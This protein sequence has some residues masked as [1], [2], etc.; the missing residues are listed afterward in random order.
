M[1]ERPGRPL[2]CCALGAIVALSTAWFAVAHA[3]PGVPTIVLESHVGQRGADVETALRPVIDELDRLGFAARPGS[4]EKLLGGRA[5]R[6]GRLDDGTTVADI[7]QLIAFGRNAFDKAKFGDAEAAHRRAVDLIR[8]NPALLVLDANNEKVTY[9]AF[10]GLSLSLFKLKHRAEATEVMLELLRMSSTPIPQADYGPKAEDIHGDAE[11]EA[12]VLGRGSLAI[13]VHDQR[14]MIFVDQKFGGMG[15]IAV[16]DLIAGPH[17]VL[18]QMPGTRG[19]QYTRTVQ[20][21]RPIEL[22]VNWQVESMLHLDD[23]WAGFVFATEVERGKET[24]YASDLVRRLG[25]A[26]VI[27]LRTML[28]DGISY[29]V[30]TQYPANGRAPIA[31]L[32]P[33]SGGE[34]LLRSLARFL[35]DGTMAA[36]LRVLPRASEGASPTVALLDSTSPSRASLL[37]KVATGV[38]ALAIAVGAIEYVRNPYNPQKPAEYDGRTPLVEVMLGGSVALGGGVYLWVR[39]MRP[40][41][42][43]TAALLG[44]GIAGLTAGAE[45]YL[46]N[47]EAVPNSP[48]YIRATSSMGVGVGLVGVAM[49]G[50]G[51]WRLYREDND[52]VASSSTRVRQVDTAPIVAIDSSRAFVGLGGSF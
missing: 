37:P 13:D 25:G 20:P 38:G 33:M 6:P 2:G 51:L 1:S 46:T 44:A 41:S 16:G 39:D 27:I 42:R 34:G 11:K 3:A 43:L 14:A 12:Q 31:A 24:I 17:Y 4:I 9:S 5:P 8:R 40:S 15:K 18:V 50:V 30:G 22:D 32:V 26:D 49:A 21:N 48:R 7:K 36:G 29:V 35:Y 47:E 10:V 52:T 28:I 45:L 23:T 19:L